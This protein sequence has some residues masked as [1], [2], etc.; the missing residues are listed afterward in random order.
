MGIINKLRT[1]LSHH[2]IREIS[3]PIVNDQHLL[4]DEQIS[5][6]EKVILDPIVA[7]PD[8][9]RESLDVVFKRRSRSESPEVITALVRAPTKVEQP[10][11]LEKEAIIKEQHAKQIHSEITPVVE[12][13]INQ[14]EIHQI[15]KPMESHEDVLTSDHLVKPT[16]FREVN[17]ENDIH[18]IED[19]SRLTTHLSVVAREHDL[20]RR[21]STPIHEERTFTPIETE[22]IH[23]QHIEHIQPIITRVIHH[24]HT[25]HIT[26]PIIERIYVK[27]VIHDVRV[28]PTETISATS[29]TSSTTST[30][31]PVVPVVPVAA[32]VPVVPVAPV[33]PVVPVVFTET[34]PVAQKQVTMDEED[35]RL[36]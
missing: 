21:S 35:E 3:A 6:Q 12:K 19:L 29:S 32:V 31:S 36:I 28:L 1:S 13:H 26:Q 2:D 16:I 33:V 34:I 4:E 7:L 24:H 27:P 20:R 9:S 15:I 18:E 22:F 11:Q 30:S 25:Q 14:T 17:Q 10:L 5:N 8:T 23:Y